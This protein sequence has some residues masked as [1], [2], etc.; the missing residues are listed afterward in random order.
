MART[1][2]CPLCGFRKFS[3]PGEGEIDI[4]T[5]VPDCEIECLEPS[6]GYRCR[7]K[8]LIDRPKVL[9]I[10]AD[11]T[12]LGYTGC[13]DFGAP[14]EG[15]VDE[16]NKLIRHGWKISVWTC[17][18][19]DEGIREHLTRHAVPFHWINENPFGPKDCSPKIYADVYLDDKAL[20]FTGAVEGLA[21]LIM[22]FR[23]WH[24]KV[25]A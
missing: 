3:L 2:V 5:T 18:N 21:D 20:T 25:R 17:R 15:I 13:S 23:P 4:R 14:A 9:A 24:N 22:A 8:D 12:M 19:A 16:L 6:C 7:V 11:G 10:D 1:K